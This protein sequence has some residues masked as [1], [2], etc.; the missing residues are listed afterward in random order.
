MLTLRYEKLTRLDGLSK[1][2]RD[3]DLRYYHH[4]FRTMCTDLR[5]SRL[6]YPARQYIV[7]VARFDPS[8]GIP[9]VVDS[10]VRLRRKLDNIL[11]MAKIPQLLM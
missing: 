4:H 3:W 5:M 6:A 8:K 10:Y 2:L 9:S 11:P 1:P 7:Q